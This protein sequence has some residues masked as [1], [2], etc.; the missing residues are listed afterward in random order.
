MEPLTIELLLKME[1]PCLV[2]NKKEQVSKV[3]GRANI[4]TDDVCIPK[5]MK[6][7]AKG[8]ISALAIL[9][10]FCNGCNLVGRAKG[11]PCFT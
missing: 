7:T 8:E 3:S 11:K 4:T 5:N 10:S 9:N 6:H 1:P 2:V